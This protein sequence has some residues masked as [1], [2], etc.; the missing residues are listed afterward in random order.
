MMFKGAMENMFMYSIFKFSLL[1]FPYL[2]LFSASEGHHPND[3][4]KNVDVPV[5]KM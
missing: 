1:N 5:K 3:E 2:A 4:K